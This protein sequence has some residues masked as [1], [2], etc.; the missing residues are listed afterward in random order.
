M[1]RLRRAAAGAALAGVL[2]AASGCASSVDPIERLGR[3]AAERMGTRDG[4]AGVDSTTMAEGADSKTVAEGADSKT[5]VEGADS[6]T[7]VEGADSTA[8]AEGATVA[9]GA[10]G[11]TGISAG[12]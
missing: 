2:L 8:V 9:E 1:N 4:D 7:V 3:K 12:P 10:E 5:V 11:R 6:K